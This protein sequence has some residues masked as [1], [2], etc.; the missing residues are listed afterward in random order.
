MGR[1]EPV[2]SDEFVEVTVR[3]PLVRGTAQGRFGLSMEETFTAQDVVG[4]MADEYPTAAG[5]IFD[6][7]DQDGSQVAVRLRWMGQD[8]YE[9][10]W[11]AK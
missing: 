10:V 9:E 5:F 4:W 11:R 6:W 8:K 2:P 1:L 7:F 3:V